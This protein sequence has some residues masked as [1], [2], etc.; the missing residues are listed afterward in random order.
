MKCNGY[1]TIRLLSF[2]SLKRFP[3][4]LFGFIHLPV[5]KQVRKHLVSRTA[6]ALLVVVVK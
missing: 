5:P 3:A 1:F 4:L 2:L 6:L